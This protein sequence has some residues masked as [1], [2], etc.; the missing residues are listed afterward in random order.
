MPEGEYQ[1]KPDCPVCKGAGFVHPRLTSGDP[2]YS[3]V[4][5]C[6]G[7]DCKAASIHEF[8]QGEVF[9]R[10]QGVTSPQQT[11]DNFKMVPGVKLAFKYARELAEG[12]SK[13]VW[14]LIYGE[15]GNGK[16]HLLNAIAL[17]SIE[18]R[19]DTKMISAADLLSLL[20][21]G[22]ADHTIDETMQGLKDIPLLLIDDLGVEYG[23]DWEMG[24]LDELLTYRYA[25]AKATVITTNLDIT[26]LPPRIRSRF[27][28]Q[29][30]SRAVHNAAPDFRASRQ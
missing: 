10:R 14:L 16:T 5:P 25:Y 20:R 23:S 18:R 2:D 13:F 17:I 4:I 24:K 30:I 8:R 12:L 22:I 26:Q 27:E 21:A 11:F 15:C 28:D 1:A 9:I 29:I 3:R 6:P 7:K 19:V